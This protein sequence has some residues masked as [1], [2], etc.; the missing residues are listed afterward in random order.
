MK[1]VIKKYCPSEIKYFCDKH[2]DRECY[3]QLKIKS[4]YGSEF[5]TDVIEV[6]L[7]DECVKNLYKYLKKKFNKTPEKTSICLEYVGR[8]LS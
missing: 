2:P 3:S 1:K 7:C 4:W 5:D 6:E 8:K